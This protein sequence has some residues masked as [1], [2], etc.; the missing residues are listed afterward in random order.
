MI[1]KWFV[2]SLVLAMCCIFSAH[3][4]CRVDSLSHVDS[5]R[6][7]A[8]L[9]AEDSAIYVKSYTESHYDRRVHRVRRHWA[10]LI[11][12]HSLVQYAGNMGLL[13]VG[14]GWDYGRHRQWETALLLGYLPKFQSH[15]GKM[16]MTVKASFVPWNFYLR[17]GWMY[18][19]LS[20]GLY[21]NTVFGSEFWSH[22]PSRYPDKYY[23]FLSTK[24]RFNVFVG[25][26]AGIIVPKSRRKMVKSI[27]AFYEISTCDLY[28]RSFVQ[29]SSLRFWDILSLS[30]GLKFQML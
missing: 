17:H 30:L 14:M 12:T 11:P 22:Q 10:S 5:V 3:A 16:T 19:P 23:P 28:V 24:V 20:C 13:S 6:F 25:Q 1:T 9:A 15:R 4:S 26:R 21:A 7:L 27:M 8:D 18:E 2:S 29:D